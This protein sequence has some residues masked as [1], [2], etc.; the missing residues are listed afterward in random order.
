MLQKCACVAELW[1]F[2]FTIYKYHFH[3]FVRAALYSVNA[4]NPSEPTVHR[5]YAVDTPTMHPKN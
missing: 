2:D 4:A 3:F 5:A 1:I